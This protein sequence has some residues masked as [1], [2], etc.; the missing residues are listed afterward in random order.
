[1]SVVR[2]I[3]CAHFTPNPRTPAAGVG[4]CSTG[5]ADQS[6]NAL[7]GRPCPLWANAPRLC[8]HFTR[9]EAGVSVSNH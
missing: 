3:E 2:C 5:R 8:S 7:T 1:M 6:R 4:T 9:I